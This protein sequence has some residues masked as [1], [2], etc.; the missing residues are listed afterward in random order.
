M[1]YKHNLKVVLISALFRE[2]QIYFKSYGKIM[3]STIKKF[4]HIFTQNQESIDLLKKL[5]ILIF[6]YRGIQDLTGLVTNL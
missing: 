1:I 6:L 5:I 2:N 4:S 3:T